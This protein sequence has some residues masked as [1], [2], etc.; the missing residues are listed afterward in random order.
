MKQLIYFILFILVLAFLPLGKLLDLNGF[1]VILII[2][3]FIAAIF[4]TYT[5]GEKQK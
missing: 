3:I 4:I 1:W 5:F 2:L